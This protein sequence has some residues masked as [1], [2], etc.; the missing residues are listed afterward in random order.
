[1]KEDRKT[2]YYWVKYDGE[3]QIAYWYQQ[4]VGRWEWDHNDRSRTDDEFEEI[5]EKQIIRE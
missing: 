2:G 1:M 3:W 5:D 4:V